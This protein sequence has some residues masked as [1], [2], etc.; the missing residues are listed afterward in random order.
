MGGGPTINFS[1]FF[2]FSNPQKIFRGSFFPKKF[3]R[4][5]FE[6]KKPNPLFFLVRV[7]RENPPSGGEGNHLLF[8]FFELYKQS[9]PFNLFHP[10]QGFIFKKFF[11][12]VGLG[13]SGG[14]GVFLVFSFGAFL[15][16]RGMTERA[17]G[18]Q[19]KTRGLPPPLGWGLFFQLFLA[20]SG[21][22]FS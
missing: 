11:G 18:F 2:F 15:F 5:G 10:L 12:I 1:G 6:K 9:Y 16:S 7:G 3:F 21:V 13:Y 4:I 14:G 20:F 17:G 22:F 19:R 8:L